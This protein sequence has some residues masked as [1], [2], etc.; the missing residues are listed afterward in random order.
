MSQQSTWGTGNANTWDTHIHSH[1]QGLPSD[2]WV[3]QDRI[4]PCGAAPTPPGSP[5][6]HA[7]LPS[8]LSPSLSFSA[9]SLCY[10]V[11]SLPIRPSC[12]CTA[13]CT[14]VR[15]LHCFTPGVDTERQSDGGCHLTASNS[16]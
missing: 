8:P 6:P 15:Q 12:H 11:M 5:S 14:Y 10:M 16:T 3:L 2:L 7:S 13:V 1:T 4:T 9:P